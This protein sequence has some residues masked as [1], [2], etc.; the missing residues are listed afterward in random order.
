MSFPQ[1]QLD[2]LK[3][4]Y[5]LVSIVH[6]GPLDYIFVGDL[7]MPLGCLPARCDVLLCPFQRDGYDS[8]LF[9]A[10]RISGPARNWN[11]TVRIADRTWHAM[12]WK[13][14]RGDLRLA[15]LVET[16]LRALR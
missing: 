7:V 11:G 5:N 9:F 13:F 14:A 12:S 15:Q 3:L 8:R 10:E 1:D 6:D 16:H 4:L 2:E